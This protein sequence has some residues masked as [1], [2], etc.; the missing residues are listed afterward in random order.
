MDRQMPGA[1]SDVLSKVKFGREDTVGELETSNSILDESVFADVGFVRE[2]EGLYVVNM[3][4]GE[5]DT[6]RMT[7]AELRSAFGL[8]K[9]D[10]SVDAA[11][12]QELPAIINQEVW[13]WLAALMVM[14]LVFEF[15]LS[16]RTP[17]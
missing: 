5:F 3:N 17:P 8:L 9:S 12:H 7:E 10:E 16:N 6:A 11:A 14:L 1:N 15:G 13:P 4:E 2:D